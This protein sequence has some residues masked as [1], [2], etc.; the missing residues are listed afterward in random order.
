MYD[1]TVQALEFGKCAPSSLIQARYCRPH[2]AGPMMQVPRC[3]PHILVSACRIHQR[4]ARDGGLQPEA[5]NI[6]LRV[7]ERGPHVQVSG[8]GATA[9]DYTIGGVHYGAYNFKPRVGELGAHVTN[10]WVPT[11]SSDLVKD[12][13]GQTRVS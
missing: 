1:S 7:E 13:A 9:W 11:I 10:I 2:P 8:M 4:V 3:R 6:E 5:H 12:S